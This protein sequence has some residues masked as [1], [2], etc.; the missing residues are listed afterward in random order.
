[1]GKSE[2]VTYGH[3]SGKQRD[4]KEAMARRI[5][6]LFEAGDIINLGFGAPLLV[7]NY[8]EDGVL[9]HTENGCVGVG[10]QITREEIGVDE[11]TQLESFMNAGGMPFLPVPGAMVFNHATSYAIIRGG[12]L[13]ATVL[14]AFEVSER[15]DLANWYMPGR[16]AGMGGAMDLCA[17]KKVVIQT[18]HCNKDGAPK[19]LHKCSLPLT[20]KGK[21]THVVTERALFEFIDGKMVLKEIR[22]G[23]DL[24]NI[25]QNT[26]ADFIIA[27]DLLTDVEF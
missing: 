10:K 4:D 15:G 14:G 26:E 18:T 11:R 12:H 2:G 13:T 23:Y 6:R 5:A 21:V 25:K 8:V 16:F 9:V 7:G 17:A 27:D 3:G 24:E 20:C 19:L 22:E 1:M